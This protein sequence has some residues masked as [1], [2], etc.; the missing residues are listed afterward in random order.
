MAEGQGERLASRPITMLREFLRWEAAAGIVLIIFSSVA[1]IL[2]N[3]PLANLYEA[4]NNIPVAVQIAALEIRKPLFLWINDGVMAIFF[5]LVGLE[6]KRELLE[7]ELASTSRALLPLMGAIGGMAM[8]AAIFVAINWDLPENLQ[9][10][11]IPAATDI[12][13]SLGVL[14][15]LGS[16]V[17]LTLKVLLTA[18]AIIDD[19]GAII[20]IALFYTYD[21]STT[22][23]VLA[24]GATMVLF[25]LNLLGVRRVGVYLVV[26]AFLWVFVLKSGV[27]ATLAGVV[28]ALSIPL[29]I[30]DDEGHSL[31]RR[32]EHKLHPWV[33]FFIL[34]L[35]GFANAGVSF[36]GVTV[37]NLFAPLTLG[38][39]LG[40]FA[41]KQAGVFSA[42]WLTVKSGLAPMPAGAQ[43]SHIYGISLL[44]G[45]GFTMSLFIG[46]LAFPEPSYAAPV[47]LGV[48]LGSIWSAILGF[49]VLRLLCRPATA[50][51]HDYNH[52]LQPRDQPDHRTES[53]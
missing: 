10:W 39:A 53:H 41:G 34:P 11:A 20:I 15:L 24:A 8:P 43:W 52:A 5:M 49:L 18:I 33:A 2:A 50:S 12:A 28:V 9:G 30:R 36:A 32:L 22:S 31:L 35:F 17:P 4:F 3:S 44:C 21:L 19:L 37:D 26:G 38:I 47:R 14:S 51:E 45:I 42:L 25:I 6:I 7:G 46:L 40:L 16:R 13:F 48:L 23:L 1:L 29:K 27:H